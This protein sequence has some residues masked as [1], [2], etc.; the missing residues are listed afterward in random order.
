MCGCGGEVKMWK[1]QRTS[2]FLRG[3]HMRCKKGYKN[4]F[5]ETHYCQCGCGGEIKPLPNGHVNKFLHNHHRKGYKYTLETRIQRMKKMGKNPII[6]PY[7]PGV[8]INYGKKT[9]RWYACIIENGKPRNVL[10]AKA[11]YKEHFG[12]VPKGYVVHHKDGKHKRITD[13]R[14][15]NLMLLLDE[16][17]LRFFP[18][19]AKGFNVPEKT[20][21]DKYVSIFDNKDKSQVTFSKL[22]EA[23]LE[24]TR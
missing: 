13:D 22:C 12:E 15:E 1:N 4:P 21:T 14:P 9:E 24:L 10:H 19:L 16:W 8:F 18:V 20:V 2:N 7:L 17:N 11:V 6:S 23:L 3:H 5:T